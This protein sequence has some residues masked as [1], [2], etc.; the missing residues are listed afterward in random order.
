ME[1]IQHL[2]DNGIITPSTCH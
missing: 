1:Q 2:L